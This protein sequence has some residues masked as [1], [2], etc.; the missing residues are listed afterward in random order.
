MAIPAIRW[1]AVKRFHSIND[2]ENDEVKRFHSINDDENDE[3]KR[4]HSINDDENDEEEEDNSDLLSLRIRTGI[5]W[6]VCLSII[7]VHS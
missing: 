1:N 5:Y 3:A 2:D 6:F 7:S 4:F